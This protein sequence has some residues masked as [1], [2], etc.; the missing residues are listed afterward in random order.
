MT[1]T[2]EQHEESRACIARLGKLIAIH[3]PYDG[4]FELRTAGVSAI[5]LFRANTELTHDEYGR[6]F[7]AAPMKDIHRLREE[8]HSGAE[9]RA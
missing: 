8:H 9:A 2:N 1:L 5:R 7:G 3:A 6:F 4:Q